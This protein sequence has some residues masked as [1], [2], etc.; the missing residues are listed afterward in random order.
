MKIDF[1]TILNNPRNVNVSQTNQL[2]KFLKEFPFC[3]VAQ[4]LYLKGLQNQE[5]FLYNSYL[6]KVAAYSP[7]RKILFDY[8]VKKTKKNVKKIKPKEI[9]G[10]KSKNE[11]VKDKLKIG[12]PLNFEASEVHTFNQWLQFIKTKP[13]KQNS[14]KKSSKE[15]IKDFLRNPKNKISLKETEKEI[16]INIAEIPISTNSNLVTE[17]L[18]Q[19]YLEQELWDEAINTYEILR[20]KYPE[21]NSFFAAK[22]KEIKK[23]I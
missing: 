5:S 13:L 3:N 1:N 8:I 20:L 23:I 2:E 4:M 11:R 12:K 17:T 19:I 18:A 22:I 15:L 6:K 7:N 14:N 21:K 16:S 10:A 9:L